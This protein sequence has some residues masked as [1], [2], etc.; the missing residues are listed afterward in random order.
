LAAAGL[1]ASH[2]RA[3]AQEASGTPAAALSPDFK[4]VLHAAEEQ[5]WPYVLSN[6]KNLTE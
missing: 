1:A 5:N 2:R 4:V 3:S 6:L